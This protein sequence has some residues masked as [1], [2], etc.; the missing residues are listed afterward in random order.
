MYEGL[1]KGGKP[2][3]RKYIEP[4]WTSETVYRAVIP[5]EQVRC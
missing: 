3:M 2:G 4:V 1:A 5:A